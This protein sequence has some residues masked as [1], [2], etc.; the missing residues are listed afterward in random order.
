M[1][2]RVDRIQGVTLGLGVQNIALWTDYEGSDPELLSAAGVDF[3][4]DDFLTMPNP[5]RWT[6]RLSL[7]F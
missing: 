2:S 5:R 1:L 4:R 3:T 7:N 6:L